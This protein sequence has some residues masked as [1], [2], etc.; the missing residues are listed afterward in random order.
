MTGKPGT[1][2][3]GRHKSKDGKAVSRSKKARLQF[4]VVLMNHQL[5]T[6]STLL[7]G[8]LRQRSGVQNS[9]GG[10]VSNSHFTQL[11]TAQSIQSK[12]RKVANPAVF[13]PHW[14]GLTGPRQ[15]NENGKARLMLPPTVDEFSAW[16]RDCFE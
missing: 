10:K 13:F 7:G 16:S 9:E 2:A 12:E 11:V 4:P 8:L 5:R 6:S 1:G 14:P 3:G 15:G